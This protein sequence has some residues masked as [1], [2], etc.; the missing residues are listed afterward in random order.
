MSIFK[1]CKINYVEML[2]KTKC[3]KRDEEI[4]TIEIII[5]NLKICIL[6]N[7]ANGDG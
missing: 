6:N 5:E 1:V 2:K 4:C 7:S 3:S